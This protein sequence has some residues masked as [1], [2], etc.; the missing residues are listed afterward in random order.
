M[1]IIKHN[2]ILI[3]IVIISMGIYICG[4]INDTSAAMQKCKETQSYD[5]CFWILN[6]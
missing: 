6:R 5:T 2:P 4:I 1:Y 3:T